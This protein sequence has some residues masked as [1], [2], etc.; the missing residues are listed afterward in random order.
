MGP[1]DDGMNQVLLSSPISRALNLNL[2]QVIGSVRGKKERKKDKVLGVFTE[3]LEEQ[4][5]G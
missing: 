1:G 3:A 2:K 4:R 5:D